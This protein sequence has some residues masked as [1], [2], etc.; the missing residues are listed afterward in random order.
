MHALA[1]AIAALLNLFIGYQPPVEP[2]APVGDIGT[3]V[4]I[5]NPDVCHEDQPCWD[6]ATMGNRISGYDE[7]VELQTGGRSC[8]RMFTFHDDTAFYDVICDTVS[9]YGVSNRITQALVNSPTDGT[10]SWSEISSD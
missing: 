9:A 10:C 4:T 2:S 3:A 5:E 1:A 7:C 6:P 8:R